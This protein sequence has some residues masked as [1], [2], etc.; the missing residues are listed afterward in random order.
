MGRSLSVNDNSYGCFHP[1][2]TER[3]HWLAAGDEDFA[4]ANPGHGWVRN[5]GAQTQ[6]TLTTAAATWNAGK[7]EMTQVTNT[8]E[9]WKATKS[10][11]TVLRS[12]CQA[13]RG[14]L[15]E[16]LGLGEV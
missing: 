10:S 2:K 16:Y 9:K 8:A 1:T 15:E 7:P 14:Y 13:P 6:G 12:G 5:S 11:A 3:T 4:D